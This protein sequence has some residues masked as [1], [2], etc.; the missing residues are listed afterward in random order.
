MSLPGAWDSGLSALVSRLRG[1]MTRSPLDSLG[2][3][4]SMSGGDYLVSMPVETWVDIEA[5]ASAIDEA[6]GALR[7]GRTADAWSNANV[8]AAIAGRGYLEGDEGEWVKR[9]RD[10]RQR[11][12]LRAL[13]C[14]ASV[15]ID[16]GEPNLAAEA[17]PTDTGWGGKPS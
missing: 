14:L 3:G 11:Q 8:A 5:A 1:L 7:A 9:Q 13:D 12:H 15:W 17:T 2:A 16:T 10:R 4:M 6:E